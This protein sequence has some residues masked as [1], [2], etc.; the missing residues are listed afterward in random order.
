MVVD[1]SHSLGLY[2]NSGSGLCSEL[3]LSQKVDFITASLSKAFS[4]R[5]GILVSNNPSD[6]AFIKEATV[7]AVFSSVISH[8]DVTRIHQILEEIK[9]AESDLKRS[10]LL[11]ISEYLRGKLIGYF[12]VMPTSLPSPIICLVTKNDEEL[13]KFQHFRQLRGIFGASF[14]SPAVSYKAPFIRLTLH[15]SLTYEDC[16]RIIKAVKIYKSYSFYSAL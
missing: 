12:S 16:N 9:C 15:S 2:G 5:A 10:H 8:S 4:T 11:K 3:C 14:L 6:I 13:R 1:E 7:P